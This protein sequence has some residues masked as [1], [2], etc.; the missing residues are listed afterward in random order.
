M[1]LGSTCVC[2]IFGRNSGFEKIGR[3]LIN[4]MRGVAVRTVV[5]GITG[6]AGSM[7]R[8]PTFAVK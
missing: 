7:V 2:C 5:G 3:I 6:Y 4:G 1:G 8:T